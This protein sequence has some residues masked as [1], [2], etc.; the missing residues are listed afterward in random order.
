MNAL[1]SLEYGHGNEAV[2]IEGG[3]GG[4]GAVYGTVGNRGWMELA[5]LS[6]CSVAERSRQKQPK[7]SGCVSR[8][9][10]DDPLTFCNSLDCPFTF[11][12]RPSPRSVAP[13]EQY[14][15]T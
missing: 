15:L 8:E 11:Q 12:V 4:N 5:S 1:H 9:T 2:G 6:A 13:T 7:D 14:G 10:L 3:G